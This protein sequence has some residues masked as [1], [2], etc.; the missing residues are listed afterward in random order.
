MWEFG[1]IGCG[2]S[3]LALLIGRFI[4][5]WLYTSNNKRLELLRSSANNQSSQKQE[6][7]EKE[8]IENRRV[9]SEQ[10]TKRRKKLDNGLFLLLLISNIMLTGSSIMAVRDESELN[11]PKEL[12]NALGQTIHEINQSSEAIDKRVKAIEDWLGDPPP[13]GPTTPSLLQ[14]RSDFESIQDELSS[15]DRRIIALHTEQDEKLKDVFEQLA[16]IVERIE[17]L[18]GGGLSER[19]HRATL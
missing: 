4:E 8:Q 6:D 1:V 11:S 14:I 16:T 2:L 19:T 3:F 17:R 10:K 7:I 18:E 9:F 12:G 13:G 5:S 15:L